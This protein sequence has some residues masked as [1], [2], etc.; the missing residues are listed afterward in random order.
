[1][2][3]WSK[4]EKIATICNNELIWTSSNKENV[5]YCIK[6]SNSEFYIGSTSNLYMRIKN[7]F[8]ALKRGTNQRLLQ[9]I[10]NTNKEFD[11]FV[12]EELETLKEQYP[13][14]RISL[15]GRENAFI[16]LYHP[17]LNSIC[18]ERQSLLDIQKDNSYMKLALDFAERGIS[19][20]YKYVDYKFVFFKIISIGECSTISYDLTDAEEKFAKETMNPPYVYYQMHHKP[21]KIAL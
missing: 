13:Y 1:M 12:L 4:Y 2:I 8:Y 21:M 10:F 14:A 9:N 19:F 18:G 11:V 20:G 15:S 16:Y 3:D 7:H 17:S 5:V 6:F